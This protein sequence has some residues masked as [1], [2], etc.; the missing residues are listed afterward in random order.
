[1]AGHTDCG[2]GGDN[3]PILAAGA[4]VAAG[5]TDGGGGGE[6]DPDG[7]SMAVSE[8]F[9]ILWMLLIFFVNHIAFSHFNLFIITF[10]S[11]V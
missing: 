11:N 4:E 1:M 6:T 2:G 7:A 10:Q 9:R 5:Q 8:M 3:D